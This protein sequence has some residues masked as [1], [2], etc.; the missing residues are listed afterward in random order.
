MSRLSRYDASSP[1]GTNPREAE[2][3]L[4]KRMALTISGLG[5]AGVTALTMGAAAPAHA[6]TTSS[7]PRHVSVAPAWGGCFDDCFDDDFFFDN[8]DFC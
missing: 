7:A 8:F 1:T 5:F 3:R 4:S 2:M 6:Q